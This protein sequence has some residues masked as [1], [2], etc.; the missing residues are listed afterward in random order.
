[1]DIANE[2]I[3]E[4]YRK[5][6]TLENACGR[7]LQSIRHAVAHAKRFVMDDAMASFLAELATVPFKVA[8]E[9]R[10]DVMN[11]LRHSARLPFPKMF[12]QFSGKAFRHGLLTVADSLTDVYGNPLGGEEDVI[13][14]IGWLLEQDDTHPSIIWLTEFFP[15]EDQAVAALP[16]RFVYNTDDTG[17]PSSYKIDIRAGIFAHGI[18]GH[19]DTN[20]GVQYSRPLDSWPTSVKVEVDE[21]AYGDE[22]WWVHRLVPEFGG[23]LRYAVALLATLN[24]IPKLETQVRPAKSFLGGGQIRKYLDHTMLRLSLPVRVSTKTLAKRLIAKARVGWHQVRP[25]WRIYHRGSKFCEQEH[26]WLAADSSGHANCKNCDAR[27]V[28]IVLPD[29]RGDPTISV[30][31]HEYR[32]THH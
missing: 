25:H 1:M 4:T 9:R 20:M 22:K 26:A 16:F 19:K 6:S 13:N 12:I 29:G 23:T 8:K 24:D 5:K 32:L 17:F 11:S 14:N 30:R 10:P 28:W 18:I 2:L 7:S 31:T 21:S 15:F 27:R 3:R